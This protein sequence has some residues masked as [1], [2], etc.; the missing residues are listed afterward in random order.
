MSDAALRDLKDLRNEIAHE[1]ETD[2]LSGLFA[3]VLKAVPELLGL[4]DKV[5]AYCGRY[6][7]PLR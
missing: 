2:D 3:A 1:Y 4:A 6:E 7:R 5:I